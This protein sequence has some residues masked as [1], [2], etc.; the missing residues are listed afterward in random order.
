LSARIDVE[1][2]MIHAPQWFERSVLIP[3]MN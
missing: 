3:K 1:A 2:A